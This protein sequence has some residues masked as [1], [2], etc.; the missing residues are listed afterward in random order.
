MSPF[1]LLFVVFLLVPLAEIYLLIQV[2]S[3]I[4]A[5]WT[6]FL[7]VFTAVVGAGLVRTQGLATLLKA[8]SALGQGELPAVEMIEGLAIFIAGALLLTPGFF[9]DAVGFACLIPPFRRSVIYWFIRRGLFRNAQFHVG[10]GR[11]GGGEMDPDAP[12]A[13]SSNRVIEGQS[14]RMDD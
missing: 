2:G 12:P 13:S 9:T 5:P 10:P 3:V 14:R 11:V 1:Q 7:V 4:G 6:I 8:Q